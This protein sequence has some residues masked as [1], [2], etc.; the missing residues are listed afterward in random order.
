MLNYLQQEFLKLRL[1]N[2]DDESSP[3]PVTFRQEEAIERLAEASARVRL[4]D[5]VTKSD[6]D[7]ALALVRKSMK[8]VGID[9]ETGE[10]DADVVETSQSKSQRTRR[11][12]VLAIIED[13]QGITL[14]EVAEIIDEAEKRVRNDIQSLKDRGQVYELDSKLQST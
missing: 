7:R 11:K 2:E 10:F 6:I 1:A 4:D 12:R 8:Q 5:E 3:V 13:K 9:P 14:E